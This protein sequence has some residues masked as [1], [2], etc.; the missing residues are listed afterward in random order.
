KLAV[1]RQDER[2]VG[3][4][5]VIHSLTNPR[6]ILEARAYALPGDSNVPIPEI[7][8]IDIGS[9]QKAVVQPKSFLDEELAI[10]DAAQ[11]ERDREELRQEQEENRENTTPL[12]RLS[13]KWVADGSDKLY[14][15]TRS[16]DS[17]RAD[18]CVAD[19]AT[20]KVTKLVEERSN[21][22]MSLKPIRL[23]DNGKEIVW[24]SERDGWGHF[25]LYDGAGKLK[26][27]ITSGEF[28]TDTVISID[29][30]SRALYFTANGRETGEDP[31]YTHLYRIGLDG[32][33][34]K[35]LTPGNFNHAVSAPD[36][37]KYF[38]DS[39]SRVDT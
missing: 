20:G 28:V 35:L 22:W 32:S 23:V 38:A 19:T 4:Y 10:S 26:N 18:A 7:D 12:Q 37:G 36:S 16:R 21:V 29:D 11:T 15:T 30:K 27:Q 39:F 24:W 8:V 6:P 31:Y 34:L 33:G 14:F 13:P 9:K 2:K 5:W 17:R 3:D 1:E 25:Y